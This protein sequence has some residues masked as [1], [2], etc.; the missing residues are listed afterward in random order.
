MQHYQSVLVA[1]ATT[2]AVLSYVPYVSSI[3]KGKT[4]PSRT[5]FGIW[6]LI[7]V[8]EVGSYAASGARATLL[9]PLVYAAGGIAVFCLSIKRGVGGT[10]KLD[11]LCLVGAFLGVVGWALTKNPH[12]ALYLSM[13]ASGCGFV[14]TIKKAYLHPETED[15][16]AWNLAGVAA[17]LNVLAVSNWALYNISYPIF[18]LL[19]DGAIALLTVFPRLLRYQAEAETSSSSS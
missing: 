16:L 12:V 18:M 11:I 7:S 9:L 4:R 13:L 15:A 1:V 3:L 19:F 14:P 2:L 8:V 5:T 10:Q 17:V 6:A